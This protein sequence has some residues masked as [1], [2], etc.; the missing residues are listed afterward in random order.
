MHFPIVFVY[1]H[2]CCLLQIWLHVS[3]KAFISHSYEEIC[4]DPERVDRVLVAAV[5]T[6]R[7]RRVG[8]VA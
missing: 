7:C 1:Y 2:A 3:K 8:L 5:S 4:R 6:R